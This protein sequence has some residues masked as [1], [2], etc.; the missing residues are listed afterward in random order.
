MSIKVF[1]NVV[2][3]LEYDEEELR[4]TNPSF[5][6][7]TL[8]I[9]SNLNIHNLFDSIGL[10]RYTKHCDVESS[11]TSDSILYQYDLDISPSYFQCS[12]FPSTLP[13]GSN[14]SMKCPKCSRIISERVF[15]IHHW[16]CSQSTSFLTISSTI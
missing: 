9:F 2:C 3:N 5:F 6:R 13:F 4:F 7:G 12:K 1:L 14:T 11:G 8:Y 15:D 10:Y 16:T